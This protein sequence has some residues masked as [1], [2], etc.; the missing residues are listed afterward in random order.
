MSL[1]L[2]DVFVYL[3][4]NSQDL[5]R[6]LQNAEARS[7]SVAGNIAGFFQTTFGNIA[8]NIVT[9][10]LTKVVNA[11]GSV[12]DA[13][14]GGNTAFEQYQTQFQ[15]L[16]GNADL[17]QQRMQEL[18]EFGQRT[19][20]ELPELVQADRILQSFGLHAPDV[21][22]HFK[23]M[24]I[25]LRTITGD[26]A[27]GTGAS[28]QE[29]AKYL[30]RF[31]AGGVGEALERFAELGVVTRSE[32]AAMGVE[33]AKSGELVSPLNEAFDIL[34]Q[35]VQQKFGGMME[36]QSQ[37]FGGMLSNL[38]D[39]IGNAARTL[40][41]PIFDR[42]KEGL[43]GFLEL[44]Q[45]GSP[46]DSAIKEFAG[47]IRLALDVAGTLL[48]M[49]TGGGFSSAIEGW[50]AGLVE[51]LQQVNAFLRQLK[52]E[53][54]GLTAGDIL[55]E[56]G[57][58]LAALDEQMNKSLADLSNRH[59]QT[60]TGLQQQL[61]NAGEK[62]G[63]DLAA[64]NEKYADKIEDLNER[65][66]ETGLNFAERITD[67]A[68][69]HAKR[70]SKIE[71]QIAKAIE[72]REEKLT[73]LKKEHQRRRRELAMNLLTAE[74]EEQYLNIQA[75][76]KAEDEKFKEQ[77][78]KAKKS[79]DERLADL[80]EQM[81]EEDAE[82]SKQMARLEKQRDKARADLQEQ[83]SEVQAEKAKEV[84]AAQA[85]YAQQ[86]KLLNDKIAAENAAYAQQQ[87]E[88]RAM[89]AQRMAEFQADIEARAAAIGQG[90][91]AAVAGWVNWLRDGF[92]ELSTSVSNFITQYATP[93]KGVLLG[94]GAVILGGGILAGLSALAGLLSGIS[95]PILAIV[96]AV[97]V[98]YTAWTQ[99][100][101]G[102]QEKTAAAL[103]FL[104]PYWEQLKG[105]FGNFI[106][107]LLPRLQ[108]V[109]NALTTQWTTV[110]AP[111]LDRLWASVQ[112]LADK[113][114]ISI[115]KSTVMESILWLVKAA[116][117]AV[118][119]A[120]EGL[121]PIIDGFSLALATALGIVDGFVKSLGTLKD[122]WGAI[123]GVVD[124]LK[125]KFGEFGEAA[126]AAWDLI[127]P[128]W[129]PGSPT[130]FETGLRGIADALNKMPD[131]GQVF[132]PPEIQPGA[133]A[134]AVSSP[135]IYLNQ[136]NH[137]PTA[138]AGFDSAGLLNQVDQRTEQL[139]LKMLYR[140]YEQK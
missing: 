25:D 19:P 17:A 13:M 15:V 86:V 87:E 2:G 83:L 24:G 53:M 124:G 37:T 136:T 112:K 119:L 65:I 82:Y 120:V 74:S 5:D 54:L 100:W 14:I 68:E 93:L 23:Q 64:I 102:I 76:I 26:M 92:N 129:K 16:L 115:D 134:G 28:F 42:L 95:A 81:A 113:L 90:P 118:L 39:W 50:A 20:F 36:A 131:L 67:L 128:Q 49:L 10:A 71:E 101:G 79:G 63:Q 107:L 75:Q 18:A 104:Q 116:L 62:L 96:A 47:T 1:T 123:G 22:E 85:S 137:L 27:A 80:R 110:V 55:G 38:Q 114:G 9:G 6:S 57:P 58:G 45:P 140:F 35:V 127:P 111:A 3:R 77:K 105:I 94:I 109:W 133:L 33:F 4:G 99:N 41:E 12:K 40:G 8:A 52:D 125:T 97:A 91:A 51:K 43:Q 29:I 126:K 66:I 130:P 84:A 48:G 135:T 32:L 138:P 11:I 88:I 122:A 69:Q 139:I 132:A 30:G 117:A 108:E 72:D 59:N 56:L 34:L 61:T 60:I 98:L 103:A 106:D 31:S 7:R 21:V 89:Y 70:R 46:V 44:V 121:N 78:D 73:D